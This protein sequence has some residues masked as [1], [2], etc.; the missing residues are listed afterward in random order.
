MIVSLG[1][2][3]E[4][5]VLSLNKSQPEF[6]CFLISRDTKKILEEEILPKLVFKLRHYDWI[7]T[8]NAELLSE[9]YS[10]LVRKLP[11]IIGKWEVD[12]AEICV[13]YTGGTK[14][15]SVALV[16]ATIEK[17]CCYS[18]VGGNERSKGGVGVVINGQERMWFLNNPWDDIAL[19]ERREVSIL[20]NKARYAS[21]ADLIGKCIDKVSRE[22]TPYFKALREMVRGYDLW[23]R[24]QHGEAKEK[25][26]KSRDILMTFSCASSKKEDRALAAQVQ[27]N[28]QFLE[29]LLSGKK[30]SILY[31]QDLLANAK[32]R[33]ELER[34]YDDAVARLYRA[35]EALA[36]I[37]LKEEYGIEPSNVREMEIPE[38]LREEYVKKY[39]DE[40]NSRIKIPFYAS[41]QL[42]KEKGSDIAKN[43]FR[44]Y[45]TKIRLV[46]DVRNKSILAHGFNCVSEETCRKLY[47]SIMSF[48]RTEED[49]L[50]K[51]PV[52]SL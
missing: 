40:T 8:P 11:E 15:M 9:C 19:S 42:L 52:L 36:Q 50:P 18:Y 35:M 23:D 6:A 12:P 37:E 45:D 48:S 1:G 31:F 22:Q 26:Y 2:T 43:F 7:I 28:I 16:L 10:E 44:L 30:P 20:F 49:D 41:F 24:F 34:K 14:T 32:R 33:A 51:F 13:D 5:V 29:K 25:L 4:P 38:T 27:T 21:A 47:D 17:S 46:L 39:K 3:P